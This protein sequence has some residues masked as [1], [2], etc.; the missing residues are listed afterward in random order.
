MKNK[1]DINIGDYV[2]FFDDT[3]THK[4]R[5]VVDITDMFSNELEA[6]NINS[7]HFD[8]PKIYHVLG[9]DGTEYELDIT[10]DY[11]ERDYVTE[12]N[13]KIDSI[14]KNNNK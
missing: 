11:L 9:D 6:I 1:T 10:K 2:T 3:S 8:F 12:R 14:L 7:K 13:I 4:K 5:F